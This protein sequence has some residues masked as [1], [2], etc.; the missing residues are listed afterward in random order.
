MGLAQVQ[1]SDGIYI[2]LWA[3]KLLG[4]SNVKMWLDRRKSLVRYILL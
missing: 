3:L 4:I 2:A 1:L